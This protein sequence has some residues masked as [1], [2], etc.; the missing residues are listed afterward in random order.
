MNLWFFLPACVCLHLP[1]SVYSIWCPERPE[2][3]AIGDQ[4]GVICI[5]WSVWILIQHF[6]LTVELACWGGGGREAGMELDGGWEVWGGPDAPPRTVACLGDILLYMPI[7]TRATMECK[8]VCIPGWENFQ[9][10]IWTKPKHLNAKLD[11]VPKLNLLYGKLIGED[12]LF[13]HTVIQV[14]YMHG[15]C[16]C[17]VCEY[18]FS[19]DVAQ[20][21]P[22]SLKL[23]RDA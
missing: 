20:F 11:W 9:R 4:R 22:V 7:W 12:V 18:C 3:S 1:K 5:Q 10:C 21:G 23:Q 6:F 19:P 13:F 8:E 15:S 17:A 14:L 2:A 16:M